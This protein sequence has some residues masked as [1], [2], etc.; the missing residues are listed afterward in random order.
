MTD[1]KAKLNPPF[2]EQIIRE[3]LLDNPEFFCR[4]PELLLA[5][6]LPHGERGTVSL[7]ERRQELLRSRVQQLEEEITALLGM[8]S[9]NEKIFR[10]N[11][12]LSLKLLDCEDMGELR[13]V[14]CAEL[15][16]AFNFSHVRLI[17]VH[18]IDSELSAI[19][20]KRLQHGYY[21][22]RLTK[23]ESKRLFGSEVGSVSLAR[24]SEQNGQVIFAIASTDVTHFHP[25][26]DNMLLD[27][28]RQLLDHLLPKL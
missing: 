3:Y 13:Q 24:L 5:M 17:T 4:H 26:M 20:R 8:A 1:A 23:E 15:K 18:D 2:D 21:F 14:L 6:R 11:T 27:Q 25:E 16:E 12:Q 7:V 10:F 9:R 19:W 28:L 22:G